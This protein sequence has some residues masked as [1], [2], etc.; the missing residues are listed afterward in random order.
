MKV[1]AFSCG[2]RGAK[3]ATE[4][5][6]DAFLTGMKEGG[7]QIEVVSPYRM[8]IA[9]CRGCFH[10][11]T[12]TPGKC[13]IDDDMKVVLAGLEAADVVVFATPVYHMTMS[14]GMKR[15]LE[16]TM[17]MMDPHVTKDGFNRARHA[18]IGRHDQKAILLSVCGFP[19]MEIFVPLRMEFGR[20]CGMLDWQPA[21]EVLRTMSGLLF[22]KKL[23]DE[24]GGYLQLARNAGKKA[25]SG[26]SI[27]AHQKYLE[28]PLVPEERYFELVN[29]FWDARNK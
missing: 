5:V 17:P 4:L 18:R 23:V 14:E 27:E 24:S 11:W 10:C 29:E 3:G 15:L 1:L 22:H 8:N 25:A 12:K 20:I 6:L 19:E 21:G 13:V 7:A 28:E 26:A 16:R 2:P 9:P